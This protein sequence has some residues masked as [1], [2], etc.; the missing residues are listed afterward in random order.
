MSNNKTIAIEYT[1]KVQDIVSSIEKL[2]SA[3]QKIAT[4]QSEI[5][6]KPHMSDQNWKDTV[7][8]LFG[9]GCMIAILHSWANKEV[10]INKEL[11]EKWEEKLLKLIPTEELKEVI[12]NEK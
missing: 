6:S 8:K 7:T 2:E 10:T 11:I 12:K 5:K 1:K 3:N 9:E 4:L